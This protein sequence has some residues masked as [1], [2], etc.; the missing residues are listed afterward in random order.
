[1]S[2][3]R[4][5]RS[6]LLSAL[7]ILVALTSCHKRKVLS[8]EKVAQIMCEIYLADQ[9]M[10]LNEKVMRMGDTVLIYD[11]VF[12]KYGTTLEEYQNSIR[13]YI[14]A[15]KKFPEVATMAYDIIHT[16]AERLKLLVG[17]RSEI[18]N[19]KKMF[20][21]VRIPDTLSYRADSLA[22]LAVKEFFFYDDST[23]KKDIMTILGVESAPYI[24]NELYVGDPSRIVDDSD[25][26][27][28][29]NLTNKD[30]LP[31]E[32]MIEDWDHTPKK[33][34]NP[35]DKPRDKATEAK[36]LTQEELKEKQ[37]QLQERREQLRKER[38]LKNE[39]EKIRE[40]KGME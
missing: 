14:S 1:M 30:T 18:L 40:E 36:P 37:R 6:I 4:E 25:P 23:D 28:F 34:V 27:D 15:D 31:Q 24:E 20:P 29:E 16:Q 5:Y 38:Q 26:G 39:I 33:G 3:L 19:F 9:Y 12:K 35:A 11:A 13:Y 7:M 32:P 8:E 22:Q 10:K 17:L 21:S 2:F